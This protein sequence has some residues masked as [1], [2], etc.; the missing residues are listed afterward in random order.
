[1]LKNKNDAYELLKKLGAPR[2]L[3][4]HVKLVDEA[5]QKLI[6]EFESLKV[7]FEKSIVEVGVAIHDAGK[8]V[9]QNELNEKGNEHEPTGEKLMLENGVSPVHARCCLSHARYEEMEVS[10][11][12]LLVALSDKLWKGKRVENLELEVIDRTAVKLGKERWDLF[13]TL[14]SC[15][16]EI[17]AE[18]DNR[19]ERSTIA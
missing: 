6:E 10:L 17:A 11:E 7:P 13:S 2:R 4:T 9:H 19:L 8:I 16:E 18:G 15:F 3:I 14:D 12:E 1:M 5:A